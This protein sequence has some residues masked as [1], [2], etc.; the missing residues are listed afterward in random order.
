MP[1]ARHA[2]LLVALVVAI[3]SA[4]TVSLHAETN[5]VDAQYLALIERL[6][7]GDKQVDFTAARLLW[8]R[9]SFYRPYC[10]FVLYGAEAKALREGDSAGVIERMTKALDEFYLNAMAH[11]VL[12]KT[13]EDLGDPVKQEH[14][15][16]MAKGLVRSILQSG[17]GKTQESA[18]VVVTLSEEKLVL[19]VF[20]LV[21][22]KQALINANEHLFDRLE[23][24]DVQTKK[25]GTLYFDVTPF[26]TAKNPL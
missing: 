12:D 3:L 1:L 5:A 4:G 26:F 14:H 17:D 6:K 24:T 10:C 7:S 13:Y 11:V 19:A 16:F 18:Y 20:G 22:T 21:Q 2:R 23:V 8:T 9:T 15:K 25:T